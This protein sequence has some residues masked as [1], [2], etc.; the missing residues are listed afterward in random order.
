MK[1]YIGDNYTQVSQSVTD[2]YVN[3]IEDHLKDTITVF[4][5]NN[6]ANGFTLSENIL[7]LVSPVHSSVNYLIN[8]IT[9]ECISTIL[10]EGNTIE[11]LVNAHIKNDKGEQECYI[12]LNT[13]NQAR[14]NEHHRYTMAESKSSNMIESNTLDRFSYDL[15]LQILSSYTVIPLDRLLMKFIKVYSN[16]I[17]SGITNLYFRVN[18]NSYIPQCKGMIY[19]GD[20]YF[21]SRTIDEQQPND[22]FDILI[23]ETSKIR[24]KSVV[25]RSSCD[26][27]VEVLNTITEIINH[28]DEDANIE[29][30]VYVG[31]RLI[32]SENY[33]VKDG[34]LIINVIVLSELTVNITNKI[35]LSCDT[36]VKQQKK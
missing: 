13:F 27:G 10:V 6:I 3:L 24:C 20:K 18:T 31:D 17:S 12:V 33:N 26:D 23:S 11:L 16:D 15:G 30:K 19:S 7:K 14:S 4:D 21:I 22:L 5:H 28:T 25:S 1:L 32:N 36:I 9:W 2:R 8:G 35:E 29:L 34:Y